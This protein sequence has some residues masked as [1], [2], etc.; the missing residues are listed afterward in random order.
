LFASAQF[1]IC[2]VSKNLIAVISC[3]VF[4]GCGTWSF[5]HSKRRMWSEDISG[6]KPIEIFVSDME[7][8]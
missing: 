4:C 2:L 8:G 7:R 6:K 3:L 5:V 1:I